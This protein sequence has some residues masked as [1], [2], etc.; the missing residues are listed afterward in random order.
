MPW[1]TPE[2]DPT[3]GE[4]LLTLCTLSSYTVLK[5]GHA[6]NIFVIGDDEGLGPH[7]K[8]VSNNLYV[9]CTMYPCYLRGADLAV[10]AGVV[11]LSTLVLY[12][13]CTS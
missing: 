2:G 8:I 12:L 10:K 5:T 6:V 3:R 1:L 13:L 11:P 4:H 7:L 9:F